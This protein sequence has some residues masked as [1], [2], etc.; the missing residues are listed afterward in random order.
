MFPIRTLVRYAHTCM[1][2]TPGIDRRRH[3]LDEVVRPAP[4]PRLRADPAGQGRS[5]VST[6]TTVRAATFEVLRACGMLDI[7]GNPGSTE[8]PFLVDLPAD[9][10]FVLALHE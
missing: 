6:G 5:T 2:F 10:R 3:D 8:V 4:R 7:F 9:L 1:P